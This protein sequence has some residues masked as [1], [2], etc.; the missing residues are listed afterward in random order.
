MQVEPPEGVIATP[1]GGRA[2][3]SPALR[4]S[5]RARP[6]RRNDTGELWTRLPFG[7]ESRL[8]PGGA[9]GSLPQWLHHLRWTP[10]PR[11]TCRRRT[12]LAKP[13]REDHT[14]A[15][16]AGSRTR[17]L[18]FRMQPPPGPRDVSRARGGGS[19]GAR[20]DS[21]CRVP[22]EESDPSVP[23]DDDGGADERSQGGGRTRGSIRRRAASTT[24]CRSES[25]WFDG[26]V[27]PGASGLEAGLVGD[28]EP[29]DTV[30]NA[31]QNTRR[32]DEPAAY[33]PRRD[34]RGTGAPTRRRGVVE[35]PSGPARG[36]GSM[37]S[38]YGGHAGERQ[39]S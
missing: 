2:G 10:R 9:V 12:D 39:R 7:G 11:R 34:A 24:G 26:R 1:T 33:S 31:T 37:T 13:W 20:A 19:P 38:D 15:V 28:R 3:A 16:R 25:R 35:P 18:D 23:F 14:H 36:P 22:L 17:S 30:R 5:A 32:S 21:T 8:V 4:S 6:P 27:A 29:R